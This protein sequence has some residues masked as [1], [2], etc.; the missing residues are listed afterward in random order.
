M[1]GSWENDVNNCWDY[2]FGKEEALSTSLVNIVK[3]QKLDG[4]DIDYEY[5]YDVSGSQSGRCTQRTSLYTDAKAQTFLNTMTSKLRSKLDALQA[6]NGYN[7]GR[8]IVTHAP[9]DSDVAR[10]SSK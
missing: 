10:T 1:G 7:R 8:Y 9:M 3:N 2:C 5:C 6:S 4:V